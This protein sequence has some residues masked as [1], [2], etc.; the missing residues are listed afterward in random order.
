M[1]YMTN[2]LIVNPD[3]IFFSKYSKINLYN[4]YIEEIF[5][6]NFR[7]TKKII[8]YIKFSLIEEMSIFNVE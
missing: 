4:S 5:D 1:D 6:L 3:I 2:I 7:L 8:N